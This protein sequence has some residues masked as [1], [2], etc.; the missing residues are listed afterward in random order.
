VDALEGSVRDAATELRFLECARKETVQLHPLESHLLSV[1][2]THEGINR[3][4]SEL[5]H[6]KE[7]KVPELLAFC[8]I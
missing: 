6:A 3:I 2:A 1:D 8:V 4:N 5:P 7:P